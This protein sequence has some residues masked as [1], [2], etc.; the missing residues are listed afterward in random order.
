[1]EPKNHIE[2]LVN[3][4]NEKILAKNL[5]KIH[6]YKRAVNLARKSIFYNFESYKEKKSIDEYFSVV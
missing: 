5:G 4:L 3:T 6:F 2:M 1:M